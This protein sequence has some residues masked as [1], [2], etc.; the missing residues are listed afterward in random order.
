VS[1]RIIQDLT[2]LDLMDS[3]HSIDIYQ[4]STL[5]NKI[6]FLEQA[7]G[8]LE[9][10]RDNSNKI[11]ALSDTQLSL[12][13]EQLEILKKELKKEKRKKFI[14]GATGALLI[15]LLIL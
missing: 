11:S 12:K 5:E 15:I 3:I 1:E 2:R 6:R 8:V 13:D 10:D 14:V 9:E 7:I 4:I